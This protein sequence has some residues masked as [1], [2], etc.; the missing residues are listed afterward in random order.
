MVAI[1]SGTTTALKLRNGKL[2]K[3]LVVVVSVLSIF[4]FVAYADLLQE[5]AETETLSSL[6]P[7]MLS[8]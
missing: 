1:A 2:A 5:T 8:P 4:F 6:L 7:S 3:L